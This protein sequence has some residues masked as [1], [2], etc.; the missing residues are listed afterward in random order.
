[1][2]EAPLQRRAPLPP[3]LTRRVGVLGVVAFALF[4]IIAFRLWYLQVLTGT[5]NAARATA[6]VVQPIAVPAPRGNILAADGSILAT[7]RNA[8]Q[9]S[10]VKDDLPPEGPAREALYKRLAHVLGLSWQQVRMKVQT[11]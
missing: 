10:V 4:G 3:Q 5:Q 11:A 7:A 2:I 6:N 8:I 1:M 9:V